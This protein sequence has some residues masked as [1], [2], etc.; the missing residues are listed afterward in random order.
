MTNTALAG[1]ADRSDVANVDIAKECNN[2]M[3]TY[4]FILHHLANRWQVLLGSQ[5]WPPNDTEHAISF[6][7]GGQGL[8]MIAWMSFP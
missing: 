4:Y 2:S 1:W 7:T 8:E 5:E 3:A 6:N